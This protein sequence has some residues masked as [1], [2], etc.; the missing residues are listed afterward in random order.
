MSHQGG[1]LFR[2]EQK[3]G[4]A[5]VLSPLQ[6][7]SGRRFVATVSVFYYTAFLLVTAASFSV[8]SAE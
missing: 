2:D 8:R 4:Y 3:H 5:L 6:Q 1:S 7:A